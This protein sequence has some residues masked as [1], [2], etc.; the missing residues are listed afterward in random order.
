[1]RSLLI[2]GGEGDGAWWCKALYVVCLLEFQSYMYTSVVCL[3][4]FNSY[5]YTSVLLKQKVNYMVF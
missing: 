4:D 5:M 2:V 1:M 3:F